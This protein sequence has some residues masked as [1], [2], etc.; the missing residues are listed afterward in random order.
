MGLRRIMV[1]V[2]AGVLGA[3]VV[4]VGVGAAVVGQ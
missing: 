1:I 2:V 4:F 3:L